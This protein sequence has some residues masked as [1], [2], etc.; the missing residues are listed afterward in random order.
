MSDPASDRCPCLVQ[1]VA[2]REFGLHDTDP[3]QQEEA[4]IKE[5]LSLSTVHPPPKVSTPGGLW[6]CTCD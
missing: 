6:L 4:V 1:S 5:R 3:I 2:T